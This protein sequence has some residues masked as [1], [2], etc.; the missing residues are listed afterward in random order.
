[1]SFVPA[2]GRIEDQAHT[3]AF[4]ASQPQIMQAAADIMA[5]ADDDA[6][7][8]LCDVYKEVSGQEFDDTDQ[9]PNGTCFEGHVR[10]RMADGSLK[11]IDSIR[12][13]DEVLTAEGNRGRVT[14]TFTRKESSGLFRVK[15]KGHHGLEATGEHPILTKRGYVKIS[16]LKIGDLVSVPRY[17]PQ[18][19]SIIQTKDH[20][21]KNVALYREGRSL[22]YRRF[23]G[24]ASLGRSVTTV[25]MT[26]V[27]DVISLTPG[28]G[29]IIGLFL[30][31]GSTDRARLVWTFNIKEEHTLV[32][33]LV[34]LL[35]SELGISASIQK[36]PNNTVKVNVHGRIW[37]DL[38]M[39][40]CG[41]GSGL[42]RLHPDIASGPIEFLEEVYKGWMDGDGYATDKRTDGVTIS[43]DLA[44]NMFDIANK[45]GLRPCLT[46]SQPNAS[47][48]VK[49]RQRRYDV[50]VYAN[51]DKDDSPQDESVLWRNVTEIGYRE[52]NGNVYNIEVEGDNSYVAESIGVHN[53]VTHGNTKAGNLAVACMAKAGEISWPGAD[54]AMEPTYGLMRYEIGY[55]K[56]NSNLYRSGDGGVGSWC[57]EALLEY[58]FL[59]MK[60]Y[61]NID[62]SYYDK[63]RVL[64]YGRNGCP[65]E[66]EPIAKEKPLR[67]SVLL[68][69]ET[70]AWKLIGQY[71]PLVHCSNQGF[72]MRRNTDGTCA[73]NDN[74][75]HCA[76][77][78]GRFTLP[79]G[80]KCLRY[81][82]SWQGSRSRGGY[83]GSA[84]TVPGKNGQIKLSG[85]QFLVPLNVV[86]HII[87]SG[88]ETYSFAGVNGFPI[89]REPFLI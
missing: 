20:I 88:K 76:I 54:F 12:L 31:E 84:I 85:C 14:A 46:S 23:G 60:K 72:S 65:D 36:R 8:D 45:L 33:D 37:S 22:R 70:Q 62:L 29:R 26:P 80:T 34:S 28:F 79:N 86:R 38:F 50:C 89:R 16:K 47:H 11:R 7:V 27:P 18:D 82:N 3:Q 56:Y 32:A 63:Q 43:H 73:A 1:M 68:T 64:Q 25:Q 52:F 66:L 77:F 30:A 49:T 15:L 13:N 67:S 51:P 6:D 2:F 17:A 35:N 55:K 21:S 61:G 87:N 53:C 10:I 75:A 19:C 44:L 41:N 42:K 69:D 58:G 74:W 81:G 9:N 83:L 48:G 78:D 4:F 40:L 24:T 57:V 39:N 59:P 5:A 71:N